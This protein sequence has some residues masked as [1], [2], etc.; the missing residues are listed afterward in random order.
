MHTSPAGNT[1]PCLCAQ[2]QQRRMCRRPAA[3][4][5]PTRRAKVRLVVQLAGHELETA[6]C[7]SP[8]SINQHLTRICLLFL[9]ADASP[10]TVLDGPL[11]PHLLKLRA[12]KTDSVSRPLPQWPH[13]WFKWAEQR[14]AKYSFTCL[15]SAQVALA[16]L[17]DEYAALE[18]QLEDC[19]RG[20]VLC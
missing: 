12:L 9:F 3:A 7:R 16:A 14:A 18:K 4:R 2:P 1:A 19:V 13:I 11:S 15:C 17:R 5:A 6:A 10:T 8:S 20:H